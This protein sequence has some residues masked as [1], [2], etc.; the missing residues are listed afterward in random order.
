[1]QPEPFRWWLLAAPAVTLIIGSATAMLWTPSGPP[2]V[3]AS[4]PAA[5]TSVVESQAAGQPV[6]PPPQLPRRLVR[7]GFVLVGTELSA[8]GG[9]AVLRDEGGHRHWTVRVGDR[10]ENLRVA[11]LG[12]D[13][14]LLEADDHVE[15]VVAAPPAPAPSAPRRAAEPAGTNVL[16]INLPP[17][18]P[19]PDGPYEDEAVGHHGQ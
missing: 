4:P 2:E 6:A 5:Q 10:V 15:R 13:H 19:Q 16:T 12:A 17:A 9:L 11:E 14:V 3:P 1:M 8:D 7:S 18:P